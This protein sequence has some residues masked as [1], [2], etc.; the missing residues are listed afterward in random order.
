[1]SY[2]V[3]KTYTEALY[4]AANDQKKLDVVHKD[5]KTIQ[6]VFA[7]SADF[8]SLCLNPVIGLPVRISILKDIFTNKVEALTL[9]FLIILAQKSRLRFLED[10]SENFNNLYAE[11][12]NIVRIKISSSSE[13]A[14][15][16]V[17]AISQHLKL[18]LR[19]EVE[20]TLE[21]DPSLIGGFKV[22]IG[23][24]IHDASLKYQL[25]KLRKNLLQG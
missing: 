11:R 20:S 3:I 12:H 10:I 18:K 21:Q 25:G 14:P 1:M 17:S 9:N 22:T 19:K 7:T 16:Q 24:V 8:K 6:N 13:M 23:D 4:E 5:M 2:R 15:T